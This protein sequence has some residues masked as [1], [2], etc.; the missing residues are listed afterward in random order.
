MHHH[1]H[2]VAATPHLQPERAP[3]S[4]LLEP[5]C[6]GHSLAVRVDAQNTRR[7]VLV[8]DHD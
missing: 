8:A 5:E 1:D 4:G 3:E 7:H 2:G 6:V